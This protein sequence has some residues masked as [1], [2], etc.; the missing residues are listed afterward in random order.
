MTA[1]AITDAIRQRIT[2]TVFVSQSLFS[3]AIIAA[4]TLTPIIAVELSGSEAAA[5]FPST[6]TLLGRALA[7]Y[8][9]GVL[10]DKAGR[11][12][13]LSTGYILAILG[14]IMTVVSILGGSFIGFV[15]GAAFIGMGRS[16]TDQGRYIA[17]EIYTEDRRA[18][19]IGLIVFA[20]T[21][22]AVSG[23][24]LV[25]PS[26]KL[27]ESL[28]FMSNT[29]PY[30]LAAGLY[31]LGLLT[32]FVFLRPDP[33]GIGEAMALQTARTTHKELAPPRPLPQIFRQPTVLLATASMIIGQLVMT[34]IMV[35]TPLYMRNNAHETTAIALVIMAHTLGMFG[36]S[37][38]TG[39]LIDRYGRIPLIIAGAGV[40]IVASILT[41]LASGVP[42]LAFA[43]FLLGLGWNFCFIAGSS[44]LADS[45]KSNERGK[46]QGTSDMM[47]S[48][49][50]GLGGLITGTVFATGGMLAIGAVGLASSLALIAALFGYGIK[51][52]Q[53]NNTHHVTK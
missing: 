11:R 1:I 50:A 34:L 19:V 5:G 6:M 4:F 48:L 12:A 38:M 8:P 21:I 27:A 13:G 16:A 2:V 51:R 40:L 35:I 24:L 23:P 30:L 52:K 47:V 42:A 44:L 7:A 46:A 17:A 43:L 10:M 25:S 33:K 20:G 45:L 26:T 28:G 14:A 29:G 22:G 18:K 41:P 49:S 3:A 37:G 9:I 39:W 36:L 53:Q 32:V 15:V 31:F